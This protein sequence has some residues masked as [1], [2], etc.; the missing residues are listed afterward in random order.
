MGYNAAKK[1]M[2]M[3]LYI[4]VLFSGVNYEHA[5]SPFLNSVSTNQVYVSWSDT[6][7]NISTINDVNGCVS[8]RVR[9]DEHTDTYVVDFTNHCDSFVDIV[10]EYYSLFLEKWVTGFAHCQ[11]G[12]TSYDNIAGAGKIR[13]VTYTFRQ[14]SND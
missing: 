8:Y 2:K 11:V 3:L 4:I 9:Y 5:N 6:S 10:Y 1:K 7:S 12:K 14:S 13:N